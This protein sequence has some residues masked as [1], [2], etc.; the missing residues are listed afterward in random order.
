MAR[1][2]NIIRAYLEY[3]IVDWIHGSFYSNVFNGITNIGPII[4]RMVKYDYD[5]YVWGSN[6]HMIQKFMIHLYSTNTN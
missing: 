6:Y 5:F 4:S 1:E 3:R 2:D